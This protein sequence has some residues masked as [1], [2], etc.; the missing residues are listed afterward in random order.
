MGSL[1]YRKYGVGFFIREAIKYRLGSDLDNKDLKT[2]MEPF[3]IATLYRTPNDAIESLHQFENTFQLIDADDKESI[4][5]GD[6]IYYLVTNNTPY[7]L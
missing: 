1:G 7:S 3:L 2:K 6:L 4:I 5:I